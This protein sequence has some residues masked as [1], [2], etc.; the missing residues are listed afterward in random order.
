MTDRRVYMILLAAAVTSSV[1]RFG[2]REN[3][4]APISDSDAYIDMAD[5]WA[6]RR[7]S[8]ETN[9]PGIHIWHYNRP[10]L[11]AVA[12]VAS[13]PFGRSSLRGCFSGINILAAWFMVI[14]LYRA[15][16]RHAQELKSP[17]FVCLFALTGF[18]QLNWGYHI[19]TD[20]MGYAT[21]MAAC[22]WAAFIFD[23]HVWRPVDTS[24][25]RTGG[26]LA[27]L[28]LLQTIAFLSRETAWFTIVAVLVFSAL[29]LSSFRRMWRVSLAC[30]AVLLVARVPH[31]LYSHHFGLHAPPV[32]PRLDTI[33]NPR[34][35]L[36]AV[37]K[38]GVAFHVVWL[39]AFLALF[40]AGKIR[41][42][43][44]IIGWTAACL[45]Y[46][47]AAYCHNDL[48]Q[49]YPLR[50]TYALFPLVYYLAVRYIEVQFGPKRAVHLLGG[51]LAVHV[52][53][54]TLGVWLDPGT[55]QIRAHDVWE[56]VSE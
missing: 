12:A 3:N 29:S 10:L 40:H 9:L 43:R 13:K 14:V 50:V 23:R 48:A 38:S 7:S 32:H 5:T 25:S 16:R 33:M 18:P 51:L 55:P 26:E 36:D 30:F 22:V 37:V 54:G 42:P 34:Y 47:A 53:I 27:V 8:F 2:H 24:H 6:G 49:G 56:S 21:A 52:V 19:L 35:I 31:L 11:P 4:L 20:T 41:V 39:P 45:L 28:L 44:F 46:V 17:I 15:L 1:L